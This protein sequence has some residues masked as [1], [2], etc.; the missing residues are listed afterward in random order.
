VTIKPG[1]HTLV[2]KAEN[3]SVIEFTATP[4]QNL[5]VW[6]QV[7][8]LLSPENHLELVDEVRGRAG[9]EECELAEASMN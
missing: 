7:K 9:V 8:G 6:Q 2:G 3:E 4:G 5:F 1:K